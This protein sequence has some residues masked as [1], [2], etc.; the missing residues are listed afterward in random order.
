LAAG[1]FSGPAVSNLGIDRLSFC[2]LIVVTVALL[3]AASRVT[4]AEET[5]GGHFVR[6][7]WYHPGAEHGNP[8]YEFNRRFRVNAP[9]VVVD[10]RFHQR[11]EPRGNGMMVIRADEDLLQLTGVEL[12][13]ELWGGHPGT[14]HKRVTLNGR[15]THLIRE[16]GTA[17]HHCTHQYPVIPLKITD[18]VNGYNAIQFACDTGTTFWGHFIVDEAALRMTLATNHPALAASGLDSLRATLDA[19]QP[20]GTN[21]IIRLSLQHPDLDPSKIARV[22]FHGRY[23]GYDENGDGDFN[24]W[25]GFTKRREPV[26]ILGVVDAP[27]F[28][29]EWN[30]AM[31]P[32]QRDMAARAVVHFHEPT[33]IFFVTPVIDGLRTPDRGEIRVNLV[34]P[35]RL[36]APFWSRANQLRTTSLFL[37]T[38]PADVIAAELHSVVWDGG[39]GDVD[40]YFKLNGTFIPV[41]GN[42]A[43]DTIYRVTPIDPALLRESENRIELLSDTEH[44][45]IEVLLPGPALMIRSRK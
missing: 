27:P 42:G 38:D 6:I 28:A 18:L 24:D 13:L 7:H 3:V 19:T 34:Q 14:T 8:G 37:G 29:L 36:P 5:D 22:E 1:V 26:G 45:G 10:P 23:F 2:S 30:T 39:A 43:H 44:H 41:A 31:L 21:E 25:H 9:E 11:N 32:A 15:G 4:A 16:I 33:N 20:D 35:P 17:D 12:Y 40:E